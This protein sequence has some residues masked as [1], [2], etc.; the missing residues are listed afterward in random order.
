M[1]KG[2]PIK[3]EIRQNMIEI[4]HFIHKAY[5]YEIYKTYVLIFPK[6]TMRSIYYHLKKGLSLGEFV[7]S[8][9]EK[10]KGDY[11]WGGEAEK[12]YYALGPNAKPSGNDRVKEHVENKHKSK[13]H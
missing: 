11:S 9:I 8:K 10:E 12:I 3:S 2:R 1:K 6:V 7:V 4:L 13:E 5:G